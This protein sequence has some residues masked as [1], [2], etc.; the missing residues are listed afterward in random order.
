MDIKKNNNHDFIVKTEIYKNNTLIKKS[1]SV[2]QISE[3]KIIKSF[4][5][6]N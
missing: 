4:L 1:T 6:K 3:E 2:F 5:L